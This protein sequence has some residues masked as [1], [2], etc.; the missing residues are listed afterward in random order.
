M[1]SSAGPCSMCPLG[2]RVCTRGTPRSIRRRPLGRQRA[3][4]LATSPSLALELVALPALLPYSN[5]NKP[6]H[7]FIVISD[8]L[9]IC[10]SDSQKFA[11]QIQN[12][13]K[14]QSK[15]ARLHCSFSCTI[16]RTIN[17]YEMKG[18]GKTRAIC[19]LWFS[20]IEQSPAATRKFWF[21]TLP[22]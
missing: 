15:Q 20:S 9:T 18:R 6:C 7:M 11:S 22:L 21:C 2:T 1:P 17:V 14:F 10:K 8:I 3:R 4:P 19:I 5:A 12:L 16:D 13:Q